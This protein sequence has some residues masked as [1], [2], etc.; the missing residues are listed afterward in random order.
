VSR[1]EDLIGPADSLPAM[2]GRAWVFG[3]RVSSRQV[4]ADEH[5]GRDAAAASAFAM[6]SLDPEFARKVGAGDFIVAGAEFAVDITHA[7]VPAALKSLG[8]AAV[9]ARSFGRF[10]L[11][12]ATNIALPAL[13]V[14]ET[15]A[16][17]TGDRLRVDIEA[18]IVANLSSGDRYVIRN[19]D[20]ATIGILRAGS[21][22]RR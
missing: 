17:K 14:E 12:A 11:R 18:H 13:V 2:S 21:V 6:A 5:V 22:A 9:I 20:D 19:V 3:D 10:F 8:I 16:V 7:V 1:Y 4:L 15:A